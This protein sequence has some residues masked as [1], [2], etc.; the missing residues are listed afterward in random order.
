MAEGSRSPA[1]IEAEIVRRRQQLSA[2]LDELATRVH[3]QTIMSDVRARTVGAVDQAA[4]RAFVTANRAVSGVKS[5]LVGPDGAP[6]LERILPVALTAIAVVGLL[7]LGTRRPRR[8]R[9]RR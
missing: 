5:Q 4:G 3:P 9:R 2:T 1:Q 7:T 6:R 8:G